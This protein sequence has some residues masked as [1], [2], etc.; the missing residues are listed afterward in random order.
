MRLLEHRRQGGEVLELN[1]DP[2]NLGLA[3]TLHGLEG[4]GPDQGQARL[5]LP[6][7]IDVNG[8]VKGRTRADELSVLL[9]QVDEIPV[10]AGVEPRRE[11]R[12]DIRGQHGRAEEN[13]VEAMAPDQVRGHVHAGL[14]KRCLERAILGDKNLCGTEPARLRRQTLDRGAGDQRRDVAF[15]LG[16]LAE[17]AE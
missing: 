9:H 16:S 1:V 3:P 2:L 6:A 10:Q 5:A 4:A 11:A 12:G 17:D 8:V 14:R 15:Q 13:G 7:D